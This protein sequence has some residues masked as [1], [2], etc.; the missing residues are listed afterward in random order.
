MIG[1]YYLAAWLV[2][3]LLRPITRL[4]ARLVYHPGAEWLAFEA[5]HMVPILVSVALAGAALGYLLV[6]S[7][8][9]LWL[10]ILGVFTA[11]SVWSSTVWF[12]RPPVSDPVKQGLE[13]LASASLA[14][15]ACWAVLRWRRNREV[16]HESA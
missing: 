8:H 5:I 1:G 10:A 14:V 11:A 2:E 16:A 15:G 4:I 6:S 9:A 3:P 13:A 12:V 7:R